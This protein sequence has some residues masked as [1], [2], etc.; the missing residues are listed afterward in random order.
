MYKIV[1]VAAWMVAERE[2]ALRGS[3]IDERDGFIHLSAA[4]QVAETASRHF[5]GQDDL[6]LVAVE[7]DGLDVRWEPSRAG[8]LFPHLYGPLRLA[9]VRRV[10]VLALDARGVHR[11]PPSLAGPLEP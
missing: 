3:P 8:A 4:D 5:A 10:E 6:R 1:P 2:G 7:T 11:L 9:A